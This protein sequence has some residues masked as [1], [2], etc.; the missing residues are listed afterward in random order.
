V[1]VTA[2]ESELGIKLVEAY[3]GDFDPSTFVDPYLHGPQQLIEAR[4]AG[5]PM[6][7][8]AIR[9]PKASDDDLAE[10]F[11]ASLAAAPN[12]K[13]LK[14][15]RA[16]KGRG[17]GA[18]AADGFAVSNPNRSPTSGKDPKD[19][20]TRRADW[21]G[22]SHPRPAP[23]PTRP[24]RATDTPNGRKCTRLQRKIPAAPEPETR[25]LL[26]RFT[27][28]T[29][30]E[31]SLGQGGS[32]NIRYASGNA[33]R[34]VRE[35]VDALPDQI[36]R[37]IGEVRDLYHRLV[38][39]VAP[40]GVG[41]TAA[42]CTVRERLGAPCINLSLEL[43]RRLLDLTERQRSLHVQGLVEEVVAETG[44]D[45]VLLD[46]TEILFDPKLQQDP[47]RCLQQMARHRTVVAA[48]GSAVADDGTASAVLTYA[49]PGHPEYRRY[50]ANDLTIV[51]EA[52]APTA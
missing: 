23:G 20:Q 12:L 3:E 34:E 15:G 17:Q 45:L 29:A 25:D 4:T 38:L 21:W 2:K 26:Q 5:Q 36:I 16:V 47:L 37:K 32:D 31:A 42:L 18:R 24:N 44:A 30:L 8:R 6:P 11:M 22:P 50:P 51:T 9:E 52:M 33:S 1:T 43:S 27:D 28:K 14:G 46:N 13:V 49:A 7:V 48:W 10:A 41:K 39:V 35:M 40:E 19:A